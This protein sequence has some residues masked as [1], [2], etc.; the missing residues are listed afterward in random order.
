MQCQNQYAG[1]SHEQDCRAMYKMY[2]LKTNNV[3]SAAVV[4]PLNWDCIL[5]KAWGIHRLKSLGREAHRP[6]KEDGSCALRCKQQNIA[7]KTV[8][9]AIRSLLYVPCGFKCLCWRAACA[10]PKRASSRGGHLNK[11]GNITAA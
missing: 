10:N 7:A 9:H 4:S 5:N 2:C 6:H 11:V 3:L 1:R 8:R